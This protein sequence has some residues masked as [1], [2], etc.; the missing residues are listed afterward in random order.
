MEDAASRS[1][2]R[3]SDAERD[4]FAAVL[5]RHFVDGRLSKDEF[6]VRIDVALHAR[7]LSELYGLIDDLPALPAVEVPTY[8]DR[9]RRRTWR[10]WRP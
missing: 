7:S 8:P 5:Q 3:A 1:G 10:W 2:P 9:P 6:G 4:W